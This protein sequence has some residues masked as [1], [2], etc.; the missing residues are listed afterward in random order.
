MTV[1]T[2]CDEPGK[3]YVGDIGTAIIVDTCADISAATT[4][5]LIVEKP[6]GTI[7]T[8]HGAVFE[9]TKVRYLVQA[10]D[11]DQAGEYSVQ[12]YLEINGWRGRGSTTAFR[13]SAVFS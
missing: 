2:N 11:F 8:W 10:G 1:C 4:T 3:Y 7:E 12:V 6:D 9:V 13:V 5:D